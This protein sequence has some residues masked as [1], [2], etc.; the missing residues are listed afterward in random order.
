MSDVPIEFTNVWK[1]FRRGERYDSLRDIIPG[2]LKRVIR[3]RYDGDL[4]KREFWALRDIS[5]KVRQG[6]AVGIIG[7]NGS[8]K[9]TILKLLCGILRADRGSVRAHGRV[10]ALIETGAG[11]HPDLT[12]RE[13]IYLNAAILGMSRT[14][15][16]RKFE[17]IVEFSG[18]ADFID[19]PVK[20]YSSGMYARLGFSVAAHVDPE[21][22]L[23]DEVLA[24]GDF[25]FQQRC[26]RKMDDV[27]KQG[28]TVIFVSHNMAAIQ[29]LCQRCFLL[30]R[31]SIVLEGEPQVLVS[32]YLQDCYGDLPSSYVLPEGNPLPPDPAVLLHAEVL[33]ADREAC[34]QLRFG[35]PFAIRLVWQHQRRMTGAFYFIRVHDDRRRLIFAANTKNAGLALDEASR[36]ELYCTVPENVLVPGLYSLSV[37]CYAQT[38]PTIHHVDPCLSFRVTEVPYR[39]THVLD[40]LWDSV[41]AVRCSWSGVLNAGPSKAHDGLEA[42]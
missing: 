5:F 19:T 37:G 15:I 23:V 33:N 18:L 10:T 29:G 2:M 36:H 22:L 9:S 20:R 13:N 42:G 28:R 38:H 11:F 6:E 27:S 7:P 32:R 39:P 25:A 34:G 31:G 12:G 16:Q 4:G 40:T 30:S 14:E 35:E 8:G 17:E 41:V 3:G 21:I 26:L 24:V 1:K